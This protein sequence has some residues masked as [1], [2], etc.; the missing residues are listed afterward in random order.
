M[1]NSNSRR[2][3]DRRWLA[4]AAMLVIAA[5][6]TAAMAQSA[7]SGPQGQGS[8]TEGKA[9]NYDRKLGTKAA[10]TAQPDGTTST[11]TIHDSTEDG[12]KYMVKLENGEIVLAQIDG[13]VVAAD[14]VRTMNDK[15]ELLDGDGNVV[16]TLPLPGNAG[17]MTTPDGA[18]WSLNMNPGQGGAWAFQPGDKV[19]GVEMAKPPPV[20]LGITMS[21]PDDDVAKEL[22]VK[23]SEA[24]RIDSVID[25]LPAGEA[26]LKEGDVI[27]AIDGNKPVNQ[28]K[29][30]EILRGKKA[31]D[32]IKL[33][34]AS[35]GE[36]QDVKIKLAA[37]N[38]EKLGQLGMAFNVEPGE[39]GA[40][41]WM[42]A[43][44]WKELSGSL[45]GMIHEHMG[46]LRPAME[47]ARPRR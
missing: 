12:H 24:I 16:H 3:V 5:G 32:V 2:N 26:G 15:I 34:V 9:Y 7:S 11:T 30:R 21:E 46:Q 19:P 1:L 47:E 20:M 33:T 44:N 18:V 29:L 40:Q 31:G 28:E 27:L 22:G 14:R 4:G 6:A 36:T 41:T 25:G 42:G 37:Y 23:P 43:Q 13:E 17:V 38:A 39:K 35:D 45:E 10:R 8:K